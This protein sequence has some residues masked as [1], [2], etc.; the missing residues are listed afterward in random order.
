VKL[1]IDQTTFDQIPE[2]GQQRWHRFAGDELPTIPTLIDYL[3]TMSGRTLFITTGLKA[4]PYFS[5][6]EKWFVLLSSSG[7]PYS[8]A[9]LRVGAAELIDA[10]WPPAEWMLRGL[11]WP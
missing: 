8:P 4:N 5:R 10:L 11:R 2:D 6:E 7:Y 3:D 9:S 1:Q